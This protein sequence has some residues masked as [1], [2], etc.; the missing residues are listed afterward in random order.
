M[1]K[2]DRKFAALPTPAGSQHAPPE[3]SEDGTKSTATAAATSALPSTVISLHLIAAYNLISPALQQIA[4]SARN[5]SFVDLLARA[6]VFTSE[7][8]V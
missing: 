1:R 2:G 8:N 6:I 5:L 7:R 4:S 3:S